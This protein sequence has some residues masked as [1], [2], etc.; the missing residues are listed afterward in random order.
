MPAARDASRSAP[1]TLK[2]RAIGNSLGVVLPKDVLTSLGVGLGD[3]LQV[4]ETGRGVEISSFDADLNDAVKWIEKGAK[5]YRNTLRA[6]S[7]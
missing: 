3:E 2:V 5:R 7:K 6:L 1:K 4:V